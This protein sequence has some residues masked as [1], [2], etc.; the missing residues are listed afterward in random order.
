MEILSVALKNFKSHSDRYFEFRPGTNAICG[1]NG[2]GKT[3]ILEAIAWT[4][5]DYSNY[6]RAELIKAG[7]AS[8]QVTVAFIS[9]QDGRTY[10]VHR[11]TSKGYEIY[12][13]GLKV[14]L[15]LKRLEDI[16]LWLREHLG[17]AANTELAKLFA[18]TIGI[19]QGTFTVDFLRPKHD[20]KR[21]FDPILKVEEYKQA[22]EKTKDL[23]SYA[24]SQVEKLEQE[25][26][27]YE[28]HLEDWA[29][30]KQQYIEKAQ[31]IDQDEAQLQQLGQQ[32]AV[33]Q[34]EKEQLT[35]Q[36]EQIKELAAQV[37]Q[38]ETQITGKK[39]TYSV[40]ERSLAQAKQAVSFCDTHRESYQAYQQ[41]EAELQRLEQC[42]KQQQ[43]I[44]KQREK[45][46]K[47]LGDRQTK[48]TQLQLQLESLSNAQL[49]VENLQQ[50]LAQQTKLEQQQAVIAQ[51]FQEV[52]TAKLQ[53][54]TA[55]KQLHQQQ[56]QL[57]RQATEIERLL[58]LAPQ[59]QQIPQL[60]QRRDRYREQLSRIEAAQQFEANLQQIV[61]QGE[62]K[63]DLHLSQTQVALVM[64]QEIEPNLPALKSA[65][66]AIETGIELNTQILA[67]LNQILADLS[68][69]ILPDQLTQKL[70]DL[71]AQLNSAYQSR[72][73][74]AALERKLSEQTHLRHEIS[75]IQAHLS[76]IE[77]Q[78]DK[79]PALQQQRAEILEALADLNNPRGRIQ[80]L[81]QQLQQQPQLQV[82]YEQVQQTQI[83]SQQAIVELDQQLVAFTHLEA[84]MD[85]Q[86]QLQQAYQPSYQ[87]YLQYE[88]EA[89]NF[90]QLEIKLQAAIAELEALKVKLE[91]IQAQHELLSQDHDP[92]HF[93]AVTIA[94][95]TTKTYK[96][97]IA[98]GLPPKREQL[99]H[100]DQQ[101]T[102]RQSLA[103]KRDRARIALEAKRKAQQF[104]TDAR[105]IYNQSGPR[106]TKFYLEE[107]S[108]EADR[109]FRELLNRPNVALEWTEDY[110]IRVQEGAY[111]RGFRS[112]SGGE[113]M[114]AAL[115]VRLALLKVLADIDVAFFDEPTTNM[116]QPRRSQLAE[117]LGNLKTF[118]QL[119][120]ISHDDT[121]ENV[122]E[123]IIR[124]QREFS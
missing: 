97:Q 105:K 27:Q 119:F 45:Q 84:C 9:S 82:T 42:R 66:T 71:Q 94:Y 28:Q 43:A 3:S 25:I 91:K 4:L 108:W 46:Q 34:I 93:A 48:L 111:W 120:V 13:P 101:L 51:Q 12:D 31:E 55:K 102:A 75:E 53:Q 78:L 107:I 59:V 39:E 81:Q 63:R 92:Q 23:E 29:A 2:A 15:G 110:E 10:E 60:E 85:N 35:V 24:K 62:A 95:E 72:A 54:K 57:S 121:F 118:R 6:T 50:L 58:N 117:A 52:E 47:T 56:T 21:V 79:E 67:A 99:E 98:G 18:D 30:L 1:E 103:E 122:T 61:T 115:A 14:K 76:Q 5:F 7:S 124:V 64:L 77:R 88:K 36:A 74:F 38:L 16:M 113:Q 8:A 70:Q 65:L 20:R 89:S 100:L 19:P 11:C 49:E 80:L 69:Q 73:E 114:C 33:L 40:L 104:I 106:I 44:L 22:F 32:L 41:V 96:D 17:V 26:V 109:L 90:R 112:L 87:I 86:R 68:E 123:N 83:G 116:D 37:K